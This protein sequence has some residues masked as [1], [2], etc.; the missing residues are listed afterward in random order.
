MAVQKLLHT[1]NGQM[2]IS[3]LLG[4]GLASLFRM[5]CKDKNCMIFKHPGVDKIDNKVYKSGN[6]C[7][8]YT[9]EQGVCDAEKKTRILNSY[10][11]L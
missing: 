7:Y 8:K 6:R 5:T 11:Y 10:I 3:I 1:K 4:L 9:V 2:F